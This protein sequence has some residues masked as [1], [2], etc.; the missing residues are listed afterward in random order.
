MVTGEKYTE[1]HDFSGEMYTFDSNDGCGG[2]QG[3]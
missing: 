3:W 1:I 2:Q